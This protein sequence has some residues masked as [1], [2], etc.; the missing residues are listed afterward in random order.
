[1]LT[2]ITFACWTY[3]FEETREP[4]NKPEGFIILVVIFTVLFS[5]AQDMALLGFLA[6]H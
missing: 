5:M 1:M 3:I 4:A 6:D 2:A